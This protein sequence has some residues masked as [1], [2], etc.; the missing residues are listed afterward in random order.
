M[1]KDRVVVVA[2]VF[3]ILFVAAGV[4]F[5]VVGSRRS[6][7]QKLEKARQLMEQTDAEWDALVKE[8]RP[9]IDRYAAHVEAET[10][11][12]DPEYQLLR[13]MI[14][15]KMPLLVTGFDGYGPILLPPRL[16]YDHL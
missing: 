13:T 12:S 1:F 10:P 15:D 9:L 7:K 14:A 3:L 11:R 6:N 4:T 5:A 8:V 2:V 16:C